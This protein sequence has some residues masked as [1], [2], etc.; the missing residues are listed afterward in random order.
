MGKVSKKT[1]C[2]TNNVQYLDIR[3]AQVNGLRTFDEIKTATNICGE[4]TGCKENIDYIL[5]TVCGCMD[6]SFEDI[7]KAVENGAD[8]VEKVGQATKAGTA[9]DCG[10]CKILIENVVA[11]GR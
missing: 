7:I 9:P 8:T 1:V 10:R 4:C 2:E 5:T 11:T 6:V 3:M